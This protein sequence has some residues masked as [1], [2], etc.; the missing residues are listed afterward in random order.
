MTYTDQEVPDGAESIALTGILEIKQLNGRFGPFPV[1]WLDSP[2]GRFSYQRLVDRDRLMRANIA[3]PFMPTSSRSTATVP[4]AS[5]APALP[6]KSPGTNWTT[7][8]MAARRNHNGRPT[9]LKKKRRWI[10]NSVVNRH[11]RL[12]VTRMKPSCCCSRSTVNGNTVPTTRLTPPCHV[13]T[14]LPAA[15]R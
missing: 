9:R 12:T 1:A 13:P 10:P 14:S 3:A 15:T 2:L 5:N 11:S 7:T 4:T 6:P 8:P